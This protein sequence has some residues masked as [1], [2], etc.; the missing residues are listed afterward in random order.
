MSSFKLDDHVLSV[1][2]L[3]QTAQD[4]LIQALL[5]LRTS[6]EILD[7]A[8]EFGETND[9]SIAEVADMSHSSEKEE[10]MLAHR[11]EGDV[12][13]EDHGVLGN[14]EGGACR[15]ILWHKASA[16]LLH[17]HLGHAVRCL[18]HRCIVQIDPHGL[19]DLSEL[20]LNLVNLLILRERDLTLLDDN[21]G[22]LN[23]LREK[24]FRDEDSQMRLLLNGH[25][26]GGTCASASLKALMCFHL[27]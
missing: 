13:L 24:I 23:P 10:V 26:C 18:L 20:G 8:V 16:E 1:E 11:G 6:S 25:S 27:G 9:L 21:K 22:V 19:H 15:E 4:L 7:D 14:R 3:L 17:I 5:D 2:Y 12:F